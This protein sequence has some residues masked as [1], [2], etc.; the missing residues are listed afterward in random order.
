MNDRLRNLLV[1]Y[2]PDWL[3]EF[4]RSGK[5]NIRRKEL[6]RQSRAGGI[7]RQELTQQLR[8]C[9][10]QPGDSLLVHSSLSKIGF[11]NGGALTVIEALKE[12][13]GP[14]G[15]LLMPTFPASGRN[16]DHL[17]ANPVF[18]ARLTPSAMGSITETFRKGKGVYRSLHPTDPVAAA[19]PLADYYTSGHLGQLTPYN[20]HSPF[21]RLA[22]KGGKI[23]MLGTTLNGAGTS[24]HTLEDAVPFPFP[25]YLDNVYEV[26][27]IDQEG[28]SHQV[29]TK[30][31]NPEMSVRRNCDALKPIFIQHGVLSNCRV[32]EAACMLI[33]AKGMFEVMIREFN[34]N[35]VTMYTPYGNEK[36]A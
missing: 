18:D 32:G 33:D 13:I 14:E 36:K 9:G 1:R 29:H 31:H 26:T 15:T 11:V 34:T 8:Q 30:V 3:L 16:K 35:G 7:T 10:I 23:L 5:K 20:E 19:G 17:D 27:I 4:A 22:E 28:R 24:L 25:V 2:S 12:T 6:Q 21:R